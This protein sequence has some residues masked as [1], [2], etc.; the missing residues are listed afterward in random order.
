[1]VQ[2]PDDIRKATL[3]GNLMAGG[4]GVEYYFGYQLPQNDL[5]C[6]DWRSRERS[7]D[8]AR[9][10][11]AFFHD[12][13]IPFWE[14]R[15]ADALVGNTKHDNSRYCLAKPGELYLVYLPMGGTTE[16]DLSAEN[17]G[18]GVKWFNPR[19]GG[20]P[21]AKGADSLNGG[22]RGTLTAPSADDWLA[23]I[24]SKAASTR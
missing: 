4:A 19:E 12:Q 23:V 13:R 3:W 18:F 6:E 8:Y 22:G 17:G 16:L 1:M 2:T 10:A 14:M 7:W 15:N 9:I 11:L 21:T 24:A 20:V 5:V